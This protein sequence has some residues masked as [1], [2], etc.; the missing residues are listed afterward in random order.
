MFIYHTTARFSQT[1]A[2]GNLFFASIFSIAHTCYEEFLSQNGLKISKILEEGSILLPIV[3]TEADYKEPFFAD[4]KIQVEMSAVKVTRSSFTLEYVFKKN[5]GIEAV[6]VS[7]VHISVDY[8]SKK[9]IRLPDYI[10]DAL[11]SI[12]V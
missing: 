9:V 7:T 3:H 10:K 2:A 12:Q 11:A 4:D 8:K 1:D 6:R 5:G